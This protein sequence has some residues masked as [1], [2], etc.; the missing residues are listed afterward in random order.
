M[1][2]V[3]QIKRGLAN[4]VDREI[5]TKIPG[6]TLKKTAVGTM[7]GLYINN[8]ER[9]LSTDSQ[10]PFISALG[11]V[12]ADGNID[13]N[14]LADALKQNVP[15]SGMRIDIDVLGFHLGDMTLRPADVDLLRSYILNA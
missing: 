2:N 7:M 6:G 11:I 13:V 10:N 15:E 3:G 1:V 12:D 5:L 9:L 4:F 14:V 8:V